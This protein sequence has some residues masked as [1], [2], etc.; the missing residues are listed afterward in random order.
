MSA[1]GTYCEDC[2]R[3]AVGVAG[4]GAL[5]DETVIRSWPNV[6]EWNDGSVLGYGVEGSISSEVD[7]A[8]TTGADSPTL[9]AFLAIAGQDCL[10]NIWSRRSEAELL[11]VINRLR[12]V[13]GHGA[14]SG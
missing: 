4:T 12:F 6:I 8:A 14:P 9:L 5:V 1:E 11:D 3:S 7:E 10:Y 2:G 13:A